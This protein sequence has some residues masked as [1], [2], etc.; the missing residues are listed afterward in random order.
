VETF[1]TGTPD[2]TLLPTQKPTTMK[3]WEPGCTLPELCPTD[4]TIAYAA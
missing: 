3:T 1:E 4:T 2:A